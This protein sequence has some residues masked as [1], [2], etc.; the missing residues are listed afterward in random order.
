[1]DNTHKP[2]ARWLRFCDEDMR[3]PLQ[4]SEGDVRAYIGYL[5]LQGRI[6]PEY[7]P[8]YISTVSRYHDLQSLPS[9]TLTSL[10]STLMKAYNRCYDE[11]AAPVLL[12]IKCSAEVVLRIL[13]ADWA[14]ITPLDTLCCVAVLLAFTFQERVVSLAHLSNKDITLDGERQT[15]SFFRHKG[16]LLRR[17][18]I[19][20]YSRA[21]Y[22]GSHSPIALVE[23]WLPST[24]SSG[25]VFALPLSH[26]IQRALNLT[27]VQPPEGC[28]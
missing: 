10:V 24:P 5:S 26:A 19:L 16:R 23:K 8:Q 2:I 9:M 6:S 14:S 3:C 4:A 20:H 13:Q 21:A 15:V 25:P 18:L 27:G 12:Q 17:P 11:T 22:W 1:M 7:L 28:V